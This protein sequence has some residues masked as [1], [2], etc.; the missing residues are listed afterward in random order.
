MPYPSKELNLKLFQIISPK[1]G[2]SYFL[3]TCHKLPD[4]EGQQILNYIKPI[5]KQAE[6]IAVESDFRSVAQENPPAFNQTIE[7]Y[8]GKEIYGECKKLSPIDRNYLFSTIQEENTPLELLMLDL[9]W[10][11]F[12]I[13]S[14]RLSY[15]LDEE[16]LHAAKERMAFLE[17]PGKI[18]GLL[19]QIDPELRTAY[20]KEIIRS[21]FNS[22]NRLDQIQELQKITEIQDIYLYKT[23]DDF[24]DFRA[25]QDQIT[26]S[27]YSDPLLIKADQA[28]QEALIEQRNTIMLKSFFHFPADKAIFVAVG[29]SHL[30]GLFKALKAENYKIEQVD[31]KRALDL[32]KNPDEIFSN[33]KEIM[34]R[35][36]AEESEAKET[37]DPDEAQMEHQPLQASASLPLSSNNHFSF[38]SSEQWSDEEPEQEYISAPT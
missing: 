36:I 32:A 33:S 7:E 10:L 27:E 15:L 25:K 38:W 22:D 26:I 16:I 19:K 20:Y 28:F 18:Q 1:G 23:M 37:K 11:F 21:C 4:N 2:K 6:I 9:T 29:A 24:E 34:P 12:P 13:K 5:L 35:M 31:Y 30:P 3:G 17:T 14:L 8:L